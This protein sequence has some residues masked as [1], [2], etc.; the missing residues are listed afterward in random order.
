[1]ISQQVANWEAIILLGLI[2]GRVP[3][4]S[5][6]EA[7]TRKAAVGLPRV[8]TILVALELSS[9]AIAMHISFLITFYRRLGW[10]YAVSTWWNWMYI[11]VSEH[12][13]WDFA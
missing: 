3:L 12:R 6:L 9:K 8:S 10:L 7:S 13:V 2:E 5:L 1:M 11:M 4:I